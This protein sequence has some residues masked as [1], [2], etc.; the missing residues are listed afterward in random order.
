MKDQ[1]TKAKEGGESMT[2]KLAAEAWA[3]AKT[4]V[5]DKYAEYAEVAKEE[6]VKQRDIYE[7]AFGVKPRRPIGAYKFFMMD[8][9]KKGKFSG[10]KNPMSESKKLWEKCPEK[11]KEQYER[12]AKKQTLAYMI[13]KL[14]YNSIQRKHTPRAKSAFN[15]FMQDKANK[16]KNKDYGSNVLTYFYDKWNNADESEKRKYQKLAEKDKVEA[17]KR[18][19][20]YKEKA[21]AKRPAGPYAQFVSERVPA[22][23]TKHPKKEMGDIFREVADEWRNLGDKEKAKYRK[24]FDK[25]MTKYTKEHEADKEEAT[26]SSKK[27]TGRK[28]MSRS[29]SR[30]RKSESSQKEKES[31]TKKVRI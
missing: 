29:K 4:A 7:I 6:Q 22:L 24:V 2:I 23:R 25:E 1:M 15:F 18:R 13:K 5:K 26:P 9:A 27:S 20:E 11:E 3:K 19:D 17:E 30:G 31:T 8:M 21:E 16:P 14:E 10:G 12:M 28:R